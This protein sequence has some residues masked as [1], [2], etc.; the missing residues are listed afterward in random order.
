MNDM[1]I[2]FK[3]IDRL[4]KKDII[5][6]FKSGLEIFNEDFPDMNLG[7]WII[8]ICSLVKDGI[9]LDYDAL[10]NFLSLNRFP[11]TDVIELFSRSDINK[12]RM[13]KLTKG[14]KLLLRI[15]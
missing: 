6:N 1:K 3:A 15:N 4:R 12:E 2:W 5:N 7:D 9:L 11:N 10:L 8:M 13:H 14:Y